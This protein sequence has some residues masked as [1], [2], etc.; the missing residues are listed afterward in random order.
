MARRRIPGALDAVAVPQA[1]AGFRQV[2]VPHVL[3]LFG[4]RDPRLPVSVEEEE[5]VPRGVLGGES[6]VGARA[7]PGG[8]E[9]I[10]PAGPGTHG[11]RPGS[12]GHA[13]LSCYFDARGR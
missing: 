5:S 8:S 1:G 3:G 12:W 10:R 6:E 11:M 4:D 13:P 9:R 7:V 2:D